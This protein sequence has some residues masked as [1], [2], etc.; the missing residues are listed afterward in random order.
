[1]IRKISIT[2]ASA[3]IFVIQFAPAG[4]GLN[5]MNVMYRWIQTDSVQNREN[6]AENP[7]E[8][9]LAT[10]RTTA[11]LYSI[12][13]PG[14]GQTMLGETYK[15]VAISLAAYGSLLTTVISHNNF[16]ARG[17]RLDALEFQ[18]ANA[19]SWVSA[20]LIYD[21]MISTHKQLKQDQNRRDLFLI[22]TAA[23]WTLNIVDVLY[24]TE[25]HGQTLFSHDLRMNRPVTS[26]QI[27]SRHAPMLSFSLP[28]E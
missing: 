21:G 14:A 5:S 6:S 27:V 16:I 20:D 3:M 26:E 28:I 23:I 7:H 9:E 22:I 24:N 17:E 12:V 15:G 8:T 13:L 1:M 18:Y 11:L 2:V 4:D 25:D 19:A 10:R